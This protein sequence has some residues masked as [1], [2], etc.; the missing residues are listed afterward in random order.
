MACKFIFDELLLS[1][2]PEFAELGKEDRLNDLAVSG[3]VENLTELTS[4]DLA[5][6]IAI[7]TYTDESTSVVISDDVVDIVLL[8]DIVEPI[9]GDIRA[10]QKIAPFIFEDFIDEVA[11]TDVMQTAI[12]SEELLQSDIRVLQKTLNKV[13]L[14][15]YN[16]NRI[17]T[18]HSFS[19]IEDE[20]KQNKIRVEG[21][22]KRLFSV[23]E[24]LY[25]R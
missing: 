10:N 2:L 13:Q 18:Q 14:A 21:I 25:S 23:L 8:S 9:V 20:A 15:V 16:I 5:S 7:G 24:T 1:I 19:A 6:S 11:Y 3:I 22:T 17:H 12:S 4:D